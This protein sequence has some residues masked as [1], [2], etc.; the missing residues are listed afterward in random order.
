[1]L[2][3]V[4]P[5]MKR[6]PRNCVCA[7]NSPL[8]GAKYKGF[9]CFLDGFIPQVIYNMDFQLSTAVLPT[10]AQSQ[11]DQPW[12]TWTPNSTPS[13][14]WSPPP[15]PQPSPQPSSQGSPSQSV[16]TPP[17]RPSMGSSDLGYETA[18]GLE[19]LLY[20]VKD[21]IGPKKRRS[22]HGKEASVT[23]SMQ[24]NVFK[25]LFPMA[26]P[27]KSSRDRYKKVVGKRKIRSYLHSVTFK[28]SHEF[29]RALNVPPLIVNQADCVGFLIG[30]IRVHL[31]QHVLVEWQDDLSIEEQPL[32]PESQVSEKNSTS[33][34]VYRG[35]RYPLFI[36]RRC[37][38][39]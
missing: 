21:K 11:T 10:F 20:A 6:R 39:G 18:K 28:N 16:S 27:S 5:T 38:R 14:L 15:S 2:W 25:R 26:N 24:E 22:S 29:T 36:L 30:K 8:A 23:M 4:S 34:D 35:K 12:G 7:N 19:M 3:I 31:M 9:P 32:L 17:P 13:S 37:H 33:S 1:M